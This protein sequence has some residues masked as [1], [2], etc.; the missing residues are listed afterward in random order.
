MQDSTSTNVT[1][2]GGLANYGHITVNGNLI[3]RDS[4][5]STFASQANDFGFTVFGHSYVSSGISHELIARLQSQLIEN[6]ILILG[7]RVVDTQPEI[8]YIDQ[9]LI[10]YSVA[11]S[12]KQENLIDDVYQWGDEEKRSDIRQLLSN[13]TLSSFNRGAFIFFDISLAILDAH[14]LQSM[15]DQLTALGHYAIL[16]TNELRPTLRHEEISTKYWARNISDIYTKEELAKVLRTHL[17]QEQLAAIEAGI[18]E[19]VDQ[20]P[21]KVLLERFAKSLKPNI[22]ADDSATVQTLIRAMHKS[23]QQ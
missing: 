7:D 17:N 19:I 3:G 11:A 15:V 21:S 18:D 2:S 4:S 13:R 14:F 12:L 6:R 10:A 9:T 8:L 23:E 22:S 20:L 5:N 16:I 1:T